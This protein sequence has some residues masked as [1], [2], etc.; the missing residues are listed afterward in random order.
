MI[1]SD[2]SGTGRQTATSPVVAL[3]VVFAAVS[4]PL[5]DRFLHLLFGAADLGVQIGSVKEAKQNMKYS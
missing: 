1:M 5:A 4:Q 2:L 3:A